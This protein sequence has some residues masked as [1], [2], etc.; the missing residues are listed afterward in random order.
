MSTYLLALVI[1]EMDYIYN[2]SNSIKTSAYT[3]L[4]KVHLGHFCLAE[5]TK[6]LQLYSELFSVPYPLQKSDL[7]DI[8]DFTAGAMKVNMNILHCFYH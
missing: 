3:V 7:L 1:C 5:D 8:P 2:Y 6:C 4:G